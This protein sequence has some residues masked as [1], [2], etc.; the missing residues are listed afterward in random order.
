VAEDLASVVRALPEEAFREPPDRLLCLSP[1]ERL[2]WLQ[3]TAYF[4]WKYKGA[5][6]QGQPESSATGGTVSS[7]I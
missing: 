4:I 3:Q 2:R 1:L 5:A 7:R 6:R